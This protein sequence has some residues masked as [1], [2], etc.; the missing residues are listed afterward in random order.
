MKAVSAIRE[1]R[2]QRPAG[3]AQSSPRAGAVQDAL[4]PLPRSATVKAPGMENEPDEKPLRTTA[5][6]VHATRRVIHN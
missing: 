4:A 2:I 1:K 6:V 5:F 3:P